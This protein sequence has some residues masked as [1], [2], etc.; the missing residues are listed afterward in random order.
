MPEF[1]LWFNTGFWHIADWNG[2]DHMLFLLV[3]CIPYGWPERKKLFWLVTAFT[4]G[5]SLS[6]A[7]SVLGWVKLSSVYIELLIPLTILFSAVYHSFFGLNAKNKIGLT[8]SITAVFGLIHGLGFSYLLRAMLGKGNAILF[9]LVSFNLG[10]ECGQILI[11]ASIL[12]VQTALLLSFNW[13]RENLSLVFSSFG[14]IVALF[15]LVQRIIPFI[16]SF[17]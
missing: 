15:L 16:Q 7:V 9:P 6:L 13:K 1:W 11:L 17:A 8:Y 5:H 4:L 3:L 10:L 12:L 14:F 2:F